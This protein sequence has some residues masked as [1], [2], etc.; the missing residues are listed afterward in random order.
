[1][2]RILT[3][4]T[5]LAVLPFAL[6][7]QEPADY[8]IGA[9]GKSGAALKTA[10]Y[11]TIK[12]H[13]QRSYDNLW[14]DF[15]TTDKRAD[16]KVWDMYSNCNFTFGRPH[17]DSGSGG[18]SE[19][20]HY[21][22]EHSFPKSWFDDATPMYTDLFHMYPTDGY[23]NGRRSNYPFG[24]VG[25]VTW[26]GNNGSKLGSAKSG[27]GYTGTVFEP[28]DEYKGD[29]ARTYFYMV[30]RY[31]NVVKNWYSNTEA[32][33]TLN[34]TAYP[35]FSTW[36]QAMLLKWHRQDPV[37]EKEINR[38]NAVYG[39]QHNRNPFI[40]H[41]EL[42]EYVWGDSTSYVW[43]Q[44]GTTNPPTLTGVDKYDDGG[45]ALYPNPVTNGQLTVDNE[46]WKAGEAI[47]IYSM[48]GA[49]VAT[50]KVADKKTQINISQ[51]PNGAYLLKVGKSAVKFVKQ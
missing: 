17:Q 46:Q 23:T 30:T 32:K 6:A 16:G 33:P 24:E 4:L 25:S 37:S 13:T 44:S 40:D 22:R 34:G 48:N 43:N 19:C 36:T 1:M 2:K 49:L 41:P 7:A 14:T 3:T 8:Y 18:T 5:I 28:A 27:L 15:Q 51:L 21:N 38:N 42:A 47:E 50:Y 11:N 45:I 31:E 39:I 29:F 35:A 26:S 9:N 10:L 20:Q 12:G